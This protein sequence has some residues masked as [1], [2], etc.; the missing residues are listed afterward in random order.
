MTMVAACRRCGFATIALWVFAFPAHAQQGDATIVVRTS[1]ELRLALAAN[2][3]ANNGARQIL[4]LRG[5]Y[6][7]DAPISVPDG[8]NLS[9]EGVMRVDSSGVASGTEPGTETT[10]VASSRFDGD[11]LTLGNGARVQ[12]LVVRDMEA[13]DG[14]QRNGNVVAVASRAA[15]DVIVASI[16]ECEIF[17]P[18]P[19]GFTQVGPTGR[20]IVAMVRDSAQES[21]PPDDGAWLR[22]NIARSVVHGRKTGVAVFVINFA[23]ASATR[24]ALSHSRIE[25]RFVATGGANRLHVVT[26]SVTEI[27]SDHNVF[28]APAES[29]PPGW[30]LFGGSS[31][32]HI[33]THES[34]GPGFNTLRMR[35]VSD[36]IQ[37]FQVGVLAVAG[38]RVFANS[39]EASDNRVELDLT[40]L[41]IRTEGIGAADFSLYAAIAEPD[42]QLGREFAIGDRNTLRTRIVESHG[43]GERANEYATHFGPL[44]STNFGPQNRIEFVGDADAFTTSNDHIEPA[45][46]AQY[47]IG[48]SPAP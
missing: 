5:T 18:N 6:P 33:P 47:F 27:E 14:T 38:R 3:A 12:G 21:L 19:P 17:S 42:A 23:G 2:P 41:H 15:R 44:K 1:E 31:S 40:D 29:E 13:A 48:H 26:H 20:G 22:V 32:P 37:G 36:R 45:P 8:V 43:S 10:L 46:S 34:A 30:M 11:I 4:M 35:S 9:G 25:G 16:I 7:I 24:V 28:A 39:G